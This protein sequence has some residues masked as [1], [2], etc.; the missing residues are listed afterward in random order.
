MIPS[1]VFFVTTPDVATVNRIQRL[2]PT[3]VRGTAT[4][5][6]VRANKS[7]IV[8]VFG[9]LRPWPRVPRSGNL[10]SVAPG[11]RKCGCLLHVSEL[12]VAVEFLQH[13]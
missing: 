9:I 4:S 13:C 10:F 7:T 1:R 12:D 3:L 2:V 5:V 6:A 8:S 11:D